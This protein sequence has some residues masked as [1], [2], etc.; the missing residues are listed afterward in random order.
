MILQSEASECGLACVAMILE[1]HGR[2]IDMAA[3]RRDNS[4]SLKGMTLAGLVG[5]AARSGLVSRP[6]RLELENLGELKL[7]CILHWEMNHFVVLANVGRGYIVIQDPAVG[8]RRIGME[9]VSRSFT[10]VALELAPGIG[11]KKAEEKPAISLSQL[12]GSILGLKRSLLQILVLSLALQAFTL[13][14]PLLTQGVMDHVLVSADRNLL[15]ILVLAFALLLLLQ[16]GIG[17]MRTWAGIHLSTQLN[18]QWMGNVLAH[19]LRL[20]MDYF[21]KRHLGDITSRMGSVGAIQGMLT[22]SAVSVVLDGLMTLTTLAVMLRY[23]PA[24]MAA[25]VAALCLYLLIRLAT[26][27][28]FRDANEEQIVRSAR[29]Q[30]HLLETLRGVQSLK[31]AGKEVQRHAAWMNLAVETQNQAIRIA[32]MGMAYGTANGLI[33]GIE[34]IVVLAWGAMLVMEN[35]FSIGMLVAYLA[36]KDQF[37]GRVVS[38]IDTWIGFRMLRLHGERLGDIVLTDPEVADEQVREFDFP[39]SPR[40]EVKG[41]GFRYAEGE[42]WILKDCSFAVEE[43][44]SIAIVGASGCGKTTLAKLMIGLLKPSEGSISVGGQDIHKAGVH[45]YRKMVGA[46]MQDDHLFAGSVADNIAF[47]D[48]NPDGNRIEEAARLAAVHEDIAAMPMGYH[49]LIGDMGTTLSGGQK[50]RVLLARALYRRPRILFLDEATSHLDV[51]RERRVNEA[52]ADLSLTRVIIAHRP[53]TIASA[54]RVLDLS[55]GRPVAVE[56]GCSKVDPEDAPSEALP[57]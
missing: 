33:F 18:L 36:Y 52:V 31:V 23:S 42:P 32:K 39:E 43:G 35:S 1:H 9:E 17:L 53:E 54:D 45:N 7:P 29:Q 13:V 20:P 10:G 11:F 56:W 46:V 2:R 4:V 6:L 22:S 16:T 19:L 49:S 15:T 27:R 25:S 47:G 57:A 21:E 50:Q 5:I 55:K 51:E 37:S 30:S 34:R 28:M 24:L 26:F 38:L 8:R 3:L 41:L 12:S 40:I 44:E 48:E 14:A